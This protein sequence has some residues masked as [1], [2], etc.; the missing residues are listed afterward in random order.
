MESSKLEG[1]LFNMSQKWLDMSRRKFVMICRV[2]CEGAE[3]SLLGTR[4][5]NFSRKVGRTHSHEYK[6]LIF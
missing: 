4:R 2:E 1:L 5:L 3:M 6:L